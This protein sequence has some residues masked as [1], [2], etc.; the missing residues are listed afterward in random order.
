MNLFPWGADYPDA[1]DFALYF[2]PGGGVA[3]RVNYLQ[4]GDLAAIIAKADAT[5]DNT[6]RAALYKTVQERLLA[7]GP[8]AILV[9]P[10]YQI[11]LRSNVTGFA[12]SPVFRV[13]LG[14]LGK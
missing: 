8:Y 4:D 10:A 13:D 7:S 2:G 11:G 6:A 1:Y 3:R 5:A 9:Q 14:K 12:Y